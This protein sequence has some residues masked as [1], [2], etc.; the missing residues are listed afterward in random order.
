MQAKHPMRNVAVIGCGQWGKNLVLNFAELGVLR[1]MCDIDRAKLAP[2]K[3]R[4][5][6]ISLTSPRRR[7]ATFLSV[8]RYE[9][10]GGIHCGPT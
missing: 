9:G 1:A 5:P 8:G 2:L 4:F 3:D 10:R 7:R 6:E